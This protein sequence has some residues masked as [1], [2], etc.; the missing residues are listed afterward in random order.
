MEV[1]TTRKLPVKVEE[2][3]LQELR[4]K[5]GVI[6]IFQTLTNKAMSEIA[7]KKQI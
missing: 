4:G 3:L 1:T 2:I 7:K 5:G 6:T